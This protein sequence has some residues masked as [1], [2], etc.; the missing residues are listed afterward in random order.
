MSFLQ[1]KDKE[2]E[3]AHRALLLYA[4][5]HSKKRS[6]RAVSRAMERSSTTVREYSIRW[7]WSD[8]IEQSGANCEVEA[9]QI[10]RHVYFPKFGVKEV[11]AVD[12]NIITPVSVSGTTPRTVTD[13]VSQAIESSEKNKP[14][15]FD[16]EVKRKH[17]MLVD[18]AIAY[19]AQGIKNQ[20]IRVTL[21][22]IPHLLNLRGELTGEKAKE[23]SSSIISESIRVQDAKAR[24]TNVLE[25]MHEDAME[26][27]TILGSLKL[28]D[29]VPP[30]LANAYSKGE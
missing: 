1:K 5:Q 29:E 11:S 27:L 17:L 25:A 26:I 12:S 6:M 2:S 19:V 28:S 13:A 24:G 7:K 23:T 4:M 22:D 3:A 8:R 15:V 10:Y 30:T 20:E 16:K 21:K 18:A 9:Q 14:T